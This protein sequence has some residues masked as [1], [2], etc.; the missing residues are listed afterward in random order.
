LIK[1]NGGKHV[2]DIGMKIWNKTDKPLEGWNEKM[3][4][5]NN[6]IKIK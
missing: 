1:T 6:K 5:I 4:F 2:P 3:F